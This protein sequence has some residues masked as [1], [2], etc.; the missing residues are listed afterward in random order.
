MGLL[1]KVC[2]RFDDVFWERDADPHACL[3][4]LGMLFAYL[5]AYREDTRTPEGADRGPFVDY[6]R[7]VLDGRDTHGTAVH[8]LLT[9]RLDELER[10]FRAFEFPR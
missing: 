1:D 7:A 5:L 3:T 10:D 4:E 2:L 9:E 6:L 8:A